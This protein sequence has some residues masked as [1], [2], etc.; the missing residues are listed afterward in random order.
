MYLIERRTA[1]FAFSG[2]KVTLP[3]GVKDYVGLEQ[4]LSARKAFRG[5]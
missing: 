3:E 5:G 4:I 1:T 2:Q